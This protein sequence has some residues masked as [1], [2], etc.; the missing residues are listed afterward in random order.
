VSAAT[1]P[2]SGEV[3]ARQVEVCG[4]HQEA[5]NSL[6]LD[7]IAMNVQLTR[8]YVV[9]AAPFDDQTDPPRRLHH[10]DRDQ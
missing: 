3:L 10:H 1:L 7:V 9:T 8:A 4:E 2:A 6:S 5:L